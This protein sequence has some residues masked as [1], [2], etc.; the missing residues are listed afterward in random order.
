MYAKLNQNHQPN[1]SDQ[2]MTLIEFLLGWIY[3]WE[4]EL[5]I[6]FLLETI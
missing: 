1:L 6:V 2:R 4:E 3:F 5:N